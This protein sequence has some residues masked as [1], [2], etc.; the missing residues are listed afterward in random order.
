V[1]ATRS[2][3]ASPHAPTVE[4]RPALRSDAD[5]IAVL[6]HSGWRDAH[7]GHVPSTLLEHRHL[8]SFRLRVPERI[9][10]TIVATLDSRIVGFVTIHDD[11]IEQL[12]VAQSARGSAVAAALIARGEQ[13][14]ASSGFDHAWLGVVAGN[15]RARRFYEKQGWR[16]TGGFDYG[17]QIEGGTLAV[18]CLRYEKHLTREARSP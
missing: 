10:T 8:E 18:P 9:A 4:L 3:D 12:Y 2:E 6:W 11:E 17:A 7:L 13:V 15:G 16:E 14:I 5:G 1:T